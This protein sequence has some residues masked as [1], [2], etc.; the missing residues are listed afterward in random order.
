MSDTP[1]E[2]IE[3]QAA[4]LSLQEHIK[5]MEALARQLREKSILEQKQL[6]WSALYGLGKGLWEDQDAQEYVNSLREDRE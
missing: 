1:L 4:K 3:K 2:T 6:D 5:L